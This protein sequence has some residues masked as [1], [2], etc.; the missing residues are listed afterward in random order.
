MIKKLTLIIIVSSIILTKG[1]HTL[2]L[3]N[4]THDIDL[5]NEIVLKLDDDFNNSKENLYV[6][7]N[8]SKFRMHVFNTT[9]LCYLE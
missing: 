6:L 3:Q 2:V 1:Y 4:D 7:S 5:L 8:W 9:K